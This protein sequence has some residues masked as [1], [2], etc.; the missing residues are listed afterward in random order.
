MTLGELITQVRS[1]LREPVPARWSDDDIKRYINN[2]IQD[3]AKL[4]EREHIITIPVT[5]GTLNVTVPTEVLKLREVYW[6]DIN[7]RIELDHALDGYP[8]NDTETGIP[9]YYYYIGDKL[10]IRPVPAL[11]GIIIL[12]YTKRPAELVNDTDTPEILYADEAIKCFAVW[13]AL[14]EDGNPLASVWEN[15]YAKESLKWL[16]V[17]SENYDRPFRVK[18][19]F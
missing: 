14:L 15:E 9:T 12:K 16:A 13:K 6:E 11:D 1:I 2:A 17:E 18:E 10:E 3:L 8:L 5:A 4:S 7:G 19:R